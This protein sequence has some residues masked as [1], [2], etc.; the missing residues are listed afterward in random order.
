MN[1]IKANPS[2]GLD[3]AIK[4]VPEL[5]TARDA[6]VAVLAATIESWSG[7]LQ[8]AQ[9]LGAIDEPGWTASIKVL[10]GLK[11][12]AKP[13]VVGQLVRTDFLPARD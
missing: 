2:V 8:R 9:G 3:A 12:L 1:E 6:Q 5:A 7:P 13:V 11:L 10:D 4:A